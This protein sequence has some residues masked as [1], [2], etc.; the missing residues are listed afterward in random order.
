M[1]LEFSDSLLGL[2]AFADWFR[3]PRG[4]T[5]SAPLLVW[6]GGAISEEEYERRRSS[7]P[8]PIR[9]ALSAAAE[10]L[11][12]AFD[13]LVVSSPPSLPRGV[14]ALDLFRRHFAEELLPGLPPPAIDG[15]AFVGNSFGAFLSLGVALARE[16][17][18]AL[19][20]I[21][22]V[23]LLNAVEAAGM[24]LPPELPLRCY[25]NLDDFAS[26]YALELR[27][28]L[29]KRDRPIEVVER[30]GTHAF[31][32]YVEN[33]AVTEALEFVLVRASGQPGGESPAGGA[34]AVGR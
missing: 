15:L 11:G 31:D 14:Q 23:G 19:A 5:S 21:A 10:R 7:E 6:V 25:A 2:H 28:E 34:P 30:P 24:G 9:T 16:D 13:A 32:D 33:G 20:T 3:L 27:D 17:C 18:R 26:P 29:A 1:K 4:R 22:G 12:L 8:E